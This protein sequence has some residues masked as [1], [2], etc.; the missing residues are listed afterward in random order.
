MRARRLSDFCRGTEMARVTLVGFI[1]AA[2]FL[3]LYDVLHLDC[4]RISSALRLPMA[5]LP[6]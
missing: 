5:R 1:V 2:I 6:E 3:C 4:G